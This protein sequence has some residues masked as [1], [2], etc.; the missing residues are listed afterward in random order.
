MN[1][2]GHFVV[3]SVGLVEDANIFLVE[4]ILYCVEVHFGKV[5][6][7]DSEIIIVIPGERV[8]ISDGAP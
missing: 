2:F 7:Y 1:T 4:L 8:S 5:F 6:V 3:A